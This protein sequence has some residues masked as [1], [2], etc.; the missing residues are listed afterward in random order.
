M[1]SPREM[2]GV[3]TYDDKIY[4]QGGWGGVGDQPPPPPPR[5]GQFIRKLLFVSVYSPCYAP[6]WAAAALPRTPGALGGGVVCR[7]VREPNYV[8]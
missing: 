4:V 7:V 8:K 2:H 5:T 3:T 6:A 1:P